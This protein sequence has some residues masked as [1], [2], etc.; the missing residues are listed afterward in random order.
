MQVPRQFMILLLAAGHVVRA[1]NATTLWGVCPETIIAPTDMAMCLQEASGAIVPSPKSARDVD[2]TARG[3]QVVGSLPSEAASLNLSNN[4]IRDIPAY[5]PNSQLTALN[6]TFNA[7]TQASALA[8]PP[9]ITTLDL[10]HNF[11]TRLFRWTALD[12]SFV[13]TLDLT[14]NPLRS[15]DVSPATFALLTKPN[16]VLKLD[17]PLAADVVATC[18]GAPMLLPNHPNTYLCVYNGSHED[19]SSMAF[20]FLAKYTIVLVALF[21]VLM[22]VRRYFRRRL[23][24][25][26]QL[27]PRDTYLSSNCNFLDNEPIQYRQTVQLPRQ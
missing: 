12:N 11:I 19:V 14:G 8:L 16:F 1:Q 17:R 23:D 10:S 26:M 13:T 25:R 9:S 5:V 22:V 6:L 20:A 24:R 7:F 18:V 3:I 21:V 27:M 4:S 15:F 2:L